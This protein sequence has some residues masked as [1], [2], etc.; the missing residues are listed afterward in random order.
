MNL[1]ELLG[2]CRREVQVC[3]GP[4]PSAETGSRDPL[5]LSRWRLHAALEESLRLHADSPSIRTAPAMTRA[6]RLT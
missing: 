3:A 2:E 5:S 6:A 1:A 4:P